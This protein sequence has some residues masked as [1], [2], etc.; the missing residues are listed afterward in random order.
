MLSLEI[1]II[2]FLIYT[3]FFISLDNCIHRTNAEGGKTWNFS[4]IFTEGFIGP[5]RSF[6]L[7]LVHSDFISILHFLKF[8]LFRLSNP[9]S[10]LFFVYYTSNIIKRNLLN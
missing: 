6:F 8:E 7:L 9:Y 3:L 10:A 4:L 1:T 2:A 5:I